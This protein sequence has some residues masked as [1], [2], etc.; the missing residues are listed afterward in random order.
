M[1]SLRRLALAVLA[2]AV[3]SAAGCATDGRSPDN[4]P[5]YDPRPRDWQQQ[6][7]FTPFSA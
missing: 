2:L 3:L 5:R 6:P 4:E 7:G 1:R